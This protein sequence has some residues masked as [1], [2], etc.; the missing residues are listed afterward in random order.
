VGS[1]AP[2]NTRPKSEADANGMIISGQYV[3]EVPLLT[4]SR[5]NALY[6]H[7]GEGLSRIHLRA[8][9]PASSCS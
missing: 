3:K 5:V 1:S 6:S 4:C 8:H 7:T 9:P 2:D